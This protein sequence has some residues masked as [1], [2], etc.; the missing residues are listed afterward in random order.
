MVL[1]S[2]CKNC[3][4]YGETFKDMLSERTKKL[5][6]QESRFADGTEETADVKALMN[7]YK[8]G[9]L[10]LMPDTSYASGVLIPRITDFIGT[11][12][13]VFLGGDDW[14]AW[15]SGY[16]GK[17]KSKY[18]YTAY[19]IGPWAL[20][21]K[22]FDVKKF[23]AEFKKRKGKE[24]PD[25]IA[26]IS[27]RTLMAVLDSLK[28]SELEKSEDLK[29]SVLAAFQSARKKNPHWFRNPSYAIYKLTQDGENYVGSISP[30]SKK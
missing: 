14:G 15:K 23:K 28:K 6:I 29:S 3:V 17:V 13:L 24:A 5:S 18:N 2:A 12:T 9:S 21:D 20:E 4:D 19:R 7:G 11:N 22:S 16:V 1:E 27:Y 8:K 25:T 30:H 10:I 26:Y